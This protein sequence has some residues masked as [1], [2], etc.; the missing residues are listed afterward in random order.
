MAT[1]VILEACDS[2]WMSGG[3]M[4]VR[5]GKKVVSVGH[6]QPVTIHIVLLRLES[7]LGM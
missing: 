2:Q 4:P 6:I 5:M 3:V 7:S 1:L